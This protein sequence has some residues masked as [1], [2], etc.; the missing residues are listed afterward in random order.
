LF[1]RFGTYP[2]PDATEA[3]QHILYLLISIQIR[4]RFTFRPSNQLLPAEIVG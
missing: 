1:A 2:V 3:Q 4:A